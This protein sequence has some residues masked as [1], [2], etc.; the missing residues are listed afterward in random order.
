MNQINIK[1]IFVVLCMS[2]FVC[3]YTFIR[4]KEK[5][6]EWKYVWKPVKQNLQIFSFAIRFDEGCRLSNLLLACFKRTQT[7]RAKNMDSPDEKPWWINKFIGQAQ[8]LDANWMDTGC[9]EV[10]DALRFLILW[11]LVS[12]G[13]SC[14]KHIW[15]ISYYYWDLLGENLDIKFH[16]YFT[17]VDFSQWKGEIWL[18]IFHSLSCSKFLQS[19]PSNQ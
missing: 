3:M 8:W 9:N 12:E 6:D 17:S 1:F 18:Q 7:W 15:C 19:S 13:F 16:R 2:L 4:I 11:P 5:N 10:A 14:S